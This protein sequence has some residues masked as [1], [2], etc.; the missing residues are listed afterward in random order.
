MLGLCSLSK[1]IFWNSDLNKELK[2]AK[3]RYLLSTFFDELAPKMRKIQSLFFFVKI[4]FK[5][6]FKYKVGVNEFINF[7]RPFFY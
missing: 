7:N 5:A 1:I 4:K 3:K 2:G 6:E